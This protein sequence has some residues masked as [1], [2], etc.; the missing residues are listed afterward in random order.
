MLLCENMSQMVWNW[1]FINVLNCKCECVFIVLLFVTYWPSRWALEPQID[2]NICS[3]SWHNINGLD[4]DILPNQ[5]SDCKYHI[6]INTWGQYDVKNVSRKLPLRKQMVKKD[7]G[8]KQILICFPFKCQCAISLWRQQ[9]TSIWCR[10]LTSHNTFM[11]DLCLMAS[12]SQLLT[13]FMLIQHFLPTGDADGKVSALC[14]VLVPFL[15][16]H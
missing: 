8:W 14:L 15:L 5:M 3:I 12:W 1:V 7:F 10:Q 16:Y 4:L 2:V 11:F 9:L 6:D 13:F